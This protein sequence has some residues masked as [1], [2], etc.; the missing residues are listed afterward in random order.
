MSRKISRMELI[1]HRIFQRVEQQPDLVSDLR[2]FMDY[3]LPTTVK[4]LDAYEELD[5]QPI[6]DEYRQLQERNR[7]Y[8]GHHQPGF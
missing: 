4:L 7:R 5:A 2:K 1:I 8:P 6:Q 3:Y